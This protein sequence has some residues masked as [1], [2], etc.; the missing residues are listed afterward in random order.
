MITK[1]STRFWLTALGTILATS[2]AN[3]ETPT[4]ANTGG[5]SLGTGGAVNSSGG[6]PTGGISNP[7][8]G[9]ATGGAVNPSGGTA[10]GGIS[11]ASG[12]TATGGVNNPSGGK[13]SGGTA[14]GG[15]VNPSGGAAT[16][17]NASGGTNTGG[18]ATGGNPTDGGSTGG[19]GGASQG[20]GLSPV[21]A[22]C[23]TSGSPCHLTVNS[24]DRTYYVYLPSGYN[25]STQYP[26][27]FQFHPMGGNA[28]Q[29]INMPSIRSS[30]T[31]IYVTPQGLTP[32]GGSSGWANSGGEDI[33]FTKAMI[34]YVETNWCVDKARLFSTGFSYGGMMSFAVGCEMSDVF[35]A[36]APMSGAL[37]SDF[38]CKGTGPHIAMW[39]S[40]GISDSVVPIADGRSARDKILQE[41]HCGST[42]AAVDPSPCVAYQGCDSGYPT[43]WCEFTGDHTIPSFANSAIAAFFKQF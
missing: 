32:D 43:T 16:G 25:S 19:S 38:N 28:E 18:K 39:G 20:C 34:T 9:T 15:T 14:T 42:T 8:G 11:N 40:H 5:S 10:T 31:A 30:F 4:P 37:Y 13:A 17:G 29:A 12:G 7:G 24:K 35:R 27:V 26:L 6:N 23:S 41:N 1:L 33:A 36:I 2:C 21:P 3:T 22:A